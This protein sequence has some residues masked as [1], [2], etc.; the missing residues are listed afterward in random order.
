MTDDNNHV[1]LVGRVSAD[2]ET[3]TLPSGDQLVTF[4]LVVRRGVAA[5]KRSKQV[6]DTIEC[7]AWR[8][9]VRRTVSRLPAGTDVEVEGQ[10]RRRFT[11]GG[12][13]MA[14]F[15]SVEVDSCRRVATPAVASGT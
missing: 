1:R 11:S 15:V 10:L 7:A 4:R 3:K 8:A 6:V 9:A 13:G 14:S 2:P 12:A 5:R